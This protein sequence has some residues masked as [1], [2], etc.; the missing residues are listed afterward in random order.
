MPPGKVVR[1]PGRPRKALARR[2][3]GRMANPALRQRILKGVLGAVKRRSVLKRGGRVP[4]ALIRS[5]N[6]SL[7]ESSYNQ[8]RRKTSPAVKLQEE[9]TV[10]QIYTTQGC[11][12]SNTAFG[13]QQNFS[14]DYLT[15]KDLSNLGK[16]LLSTSL[17]SYYSAFGALPAKV[18][19][20]KYL[21][22][23]LQLTFT[24]S[25]VSTAPVELD[26]YDIVCK[27]DIPITQTFQNAGTSTNY[28]C[29]AYPSDYWR[30]GSLMNNGLH[31]DQPVP[32]TFLGARPTDATIFNDYFKIKSKKRIL[33]SQGGCHRHSVSLKVNQFVDSTMTNMNN[34][35]Y[36]WRKL[37]GYLMYNI[38]GLPVSSTGD[39]PVVT[40]SSGHLDV[41]TTYR[42]KFSGVSNNLAY[43]Q[44]IDTLSSPVNAN[45]VNVG[46]GIVEPITFVP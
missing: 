38:K 45:I 19:P 1:G 43:V 23:S 36:A 4:G 31:I 6:G 24:F 39:D 21:V 40:T 16:M 44:N 22:E 34:V 30:Q 11:T 26:L 35:I 18:I 25:N 10:A 2:L 20:T 12:R 28:I 9:L 15:N 7:T 29:P 3:R 33:L 41:L 17:P 32:A 37:S 8:V 42:Y 46:S 27:R 13:F 14:I 5:L